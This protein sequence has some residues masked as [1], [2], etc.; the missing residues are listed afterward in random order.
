M[1][2]V[3]T[4][5]L[6]KKERFAFWRD[7][8]R[9]SP[10]GLEVSD[11]APFDFEVTARGIE[12]AGLRVMRIKSSASR[13]LRRPE[14]SHDGADHAV[15]NFVRS[16]TLM[17]EQHG[18]S[19]LVR[20][21]EAALCVADRPYSL[22]FTD[23]LDVVVFKIP[24]NLYLQQVAMEKVTAMNLAAAGQVG[25]LLHNYAI[26]FGERAHTFDPLIGARLSRNLMD[27]LETTL[28]LMSGGEI[29][30]GKLH[31]QTTLM[32]IKAL[33]NDEMANP[34]LSVGFVAARMG[35]SPRYINKLFSGEAS[36]LGRFILRRRIENAARDLANPDLAIESIRTIAQR[37]GFIDIS[38]FSRSFRAHHGMSPTAYRGRG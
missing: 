24:R 7:F 3:S 27:L 5:H 31:G 10:I 32:R 15:L 9:N 23:P 28:S 14:T 29:D 19:T 34:C 12:L 22:E 16:G 38:H 21:G 25:S 36:S 37:N 20:A 6:P 1:V 26:D 17:A 30:R 11:P 33:V 8:S 13:I 18:R 4:A 35:L 2:S